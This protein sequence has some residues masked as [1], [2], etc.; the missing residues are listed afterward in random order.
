MVRLVQAHQHCGDKRNTS[1][2]WIVAR[3]LVSG[4]DGFTANSSKVPMPVP[5][6]RDGSL[7]PRT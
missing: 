6:R 4:K 7:M 3:D 1:I 2:I 5:G